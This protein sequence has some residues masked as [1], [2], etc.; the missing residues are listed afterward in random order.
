MKKVKTQPTGWKKISVNLIRDL[1]LEYIKYSW[2]FP[3][4][5]VFKNPPANAGDTRSRPGLGRSH[6]PL[7]N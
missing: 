4:G 2:D 1:Y 3:G 5:T 6:M 7:S